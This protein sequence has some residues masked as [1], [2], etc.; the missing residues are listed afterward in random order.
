MPVG[1]LASA[2]VGDEIVLQPGIQGAAGETPRAR[3]C[4]TQL[5]VQR[6]DVPGTDGVAVIALAR[7]PRYRAEVRVVTGRVVLG[8]AS[9]ATG[10]LVLVV[11]GDGV[12]DCLLLPPGLVVY[13]VER[14]QTAAVVLLVA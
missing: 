10:G 14:G 4:V 2:G 11:A 3:R 6:D 8:R 7:I 12:R 5:R 9:G 1:E 13:L